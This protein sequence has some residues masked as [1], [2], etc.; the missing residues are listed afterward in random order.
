MELDEKAYAQEAGRMWWIF[1]MTGI[2]WLLIAWLVLRYNNNPATSV[3]TVGV[4]IGL[5]FLF[6]AITEFAA[7]AA[8]TGGWKWLHLTLGVFFIIG[9]LWGFFEPIDTFFALAS[10]LGLLLFLMGGM[11]VM[12]A[13]A[14]KGVNDLWW[15]SLV[16]G[17][18]YLLLAIWA[19]QQLYPARAALILLWVGFLALFKGISQITLAFVVRKMGHEAA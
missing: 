15:M 19:S 4:L 10:V 17:I 7:S 8:S 2:A 3:A 1:L 18:L 11:E 6:A 14:T 13:V 12:K 16:L 5:M 9:A